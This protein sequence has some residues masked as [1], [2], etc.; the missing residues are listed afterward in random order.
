MAFKKLAFGQQSLAST[1]SQQ[2]SSIFPQK[3]FFGFSAVPQ[4]FFLCF[5]LYKKYFLRRQFITN[6]FSYL[7]KV[8]RSA[9]LRAIITF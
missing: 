7:F 9:L 4:N 8:W 1:S 2:N 3:Y 5:L 6:F